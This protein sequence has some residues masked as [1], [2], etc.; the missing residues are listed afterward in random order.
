MA[1][2]LDS[3][4]LTPF[5]PL[6]PLLQKASGDKV[7]VKDQCTTSS[8]L[9]SPSLCRGGPA[10]TAPTRRSAAILRSRLGLQGPGCTVDLSPAARRIPVQVTLSEEWP[11]LQEPR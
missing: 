5:L 1:E 3:L 10:P 4:D 6:E 11:S 9:H 8:T 7:V 2:C